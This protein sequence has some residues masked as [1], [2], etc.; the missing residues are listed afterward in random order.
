MERQELLRKLES[1]AQL[2]T[3]A[4]Q[5]YDEAL[6]HVTDEDVRTN[7]MR[8]QGEH[9]YHAEQLALAIVRLG[10]RR[11]ELKVDMAGHFADWMTSIRSMGGAE[12]A[13][14]AMTTAERYH[15]RRYGDA[16]SWDL[17]DDDTTTLIRRFAEDERQH[18]VYVEERV[19]A[20]KTAG[21]VR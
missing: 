1:L 15:N 18:L 19:Q 6:E 2:D 5:V 8:F 16:A 12:G 10:G 17:G 14:H 20:A 21:G 11:P 9:R 4:V 13:L 7:F 3:D